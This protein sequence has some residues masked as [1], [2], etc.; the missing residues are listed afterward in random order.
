M[1]LLNFSCSF[2][3]R[4]TETE[5]ERDKDRQTDRKTDRHTETGRQTD[6]QTDQDRN[7]QRHRQR[8][9]QRQTESMQSLLIQG[10]KKSLRCAFMFD[11]TQWSLPQKQK[12]L[13]CIL[14]ELFVILKQH[15]FALLFSTKSHFHLNSVV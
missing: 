10:G 13:N 5:T 1:Y 4:E 9:R 3:E 2:K 8:H 12:L 14:V 6:R 11:I 7:R 15:I